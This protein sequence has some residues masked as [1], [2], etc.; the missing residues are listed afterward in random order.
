MS[1]LE[2]NR[3]LVVTAHPDDTDF[4]AGGTIATLTGKGTEVTY[5]VVS[6]GD[7][8]GQGRHA[9]G[10]ELGKRRRVEQCA[11][12]AIVGV[13]DVR[14]LGYPDG[15]IQASFDLRRDIVRMIRQVRPEVVIT[16]SPERNYQYIP[17]SH[18]DHRA[19]GGATLDAVYPDARNSCTF[20]EL[21]TDEGLDVWAVREVWLFGGMTPNHHVD[22]TASFDLK[23]SALRAHESQHAHINGLEGYVRRLYGKWAREAGLP[24]GHYAELFQV[25]PTTI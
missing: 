6:D 24:E 25:V 8:G 21:L 17:P 12:A 11:A 9:S 5:C 10:D 2:I 18:P 3:M 14:F 20:P 1:S 15:R 23:L 19:V 16:H 22:V 13:T 4:G 7:A